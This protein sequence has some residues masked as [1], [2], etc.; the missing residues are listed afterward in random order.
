MFFAWIWKGH[1]DDHDHEGGSCFFF[2]FW[3]LLGRKFLAFA[4]TATTAAAA[5]V[6]ACQLGLDCWI[7][8][9]RGGN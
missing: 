3:R 1:D 4:A 8:L 7:A 5:C 2:A 6:Y 9:L